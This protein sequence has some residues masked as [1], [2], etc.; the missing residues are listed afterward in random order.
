MAR[1][2]IIAVIGGGNT[3][4]DA[5]RTSKRLGAEH[6]YLIYRRSREEMPAR[7]EEVHHAEQEGIEFMLLTA[8]TRIFADHNNWVRAI[9]CQKMELGQ[10]DESGRRR[11]V[12]MKGSE[13]R[14]EVETVIEAIG[15][16]PNPIIQSTTP[17]LETAKKG[18]VVT[19]ERQQTSRPG[20][21]AGGDLARGGAT[22]ILAMRD[23]KIA[24][25]AIHEYLT[26]PSAVPHVMTSAEA[27]A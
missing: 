2:P 6:A 23:G 26:Q 13:F 7:L 21:F 15:Q 4:M 3:A 25:A 22:V 8:P 9:E 1:K 5:V 12:P 24:A 17:G 14:L 27:T 20:I 19:N 18:V 11:P 10:P 16:S